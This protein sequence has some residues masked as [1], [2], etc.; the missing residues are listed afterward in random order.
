MPSINE[1]FQKRVSEIVSDAKGSTLVF[2]KGFGI[3]QIQ[4]LIKHPLSILDSGDL[5]RTGALDVVALNEKWLDIISTIKLSQR[6]LV[7][8]YEEL[9][10]IQEFLPRIQVDKIIVVENNILSPWEPSCLPYEQAL[11]LFDYQQEEHEPRDNLLQLLTRFYGDVKLLDGEKALVLP[12][13]LDDETIT[14]ESFWNDEVVLVNIGEAE[15]IE[16]DSTRD[17]IY[18]L[19]LLNGMNTPA[20]FLQNGNK[21]EPR[22]HA[23]ASALTSLG[24]EF[25]IEELDLYIEQKEYDDEQFLPCL[26]KYWGGDAYFR[27]LSFYKDPDRSRDIEVMSQGY[28]ISEIVDQCERAMDGDTYSNVFITAPT[29]SGKS[30]L[31]QL[32]A[33]HL[34]EKYNLVTIVVSPLIALMNDQVDQLQRERGISIAACIN[35]SMT[36]DERIDTIGQVQSGR[37]SLLYLAPELLLTTHLQTFLGGRNVGL[38]VI[39]EAHTVTSWGRDFRSDYWFLGDFIKK[40]KR[41]GLTFPVLCL[42]ATAVYSGKDDVVKDTIHELGLDK[43]ILHIGNVKRENI[44][45][46]IL[47]HDKDKLMTKVETVKMALTLDRMRKFILNQEKVL[48]Y[49]PYRSQVDQIHSLLEAKERIKVRRYHGK[50]PS[51]ERKIVERSYKTG[52]ALGL[53]CTKAFGMGIDVSDIAHVIHF[54][55]TGTLADY[56]QEIGRAARNPNIQGVAHI[57]Y[58]PSDLRYV[59]VLNGISEMRQYQLKEMLKKICAIYNAKKRRNLLISSETFEY[60][61]KEEE[62]ENR[63]KCGLMLL[64][65]DLDNKY[66]FPVLVVRPKTM[67]SKNYVNVPAEIESAWIRK[68]GCYAK[69]QDGDSDRT[70]LSRNQA[71][72]S[73]VKVYSTGN[74]FLVNMS[75]IWENCYPDRSFGLFK[76]E[77]FEEEFPADG[78]KY[79]VAP[80]ARVEI[81]YTKDYHTVCQKIECVLGT[82]VD[83]FGK[84]KNAAIKQFTQQQ[85]EADMAEIMGEKIVAHDKMTL[86]LDV[87]TENVDENAAYTQDRSQIRVLRKRKQVGT[88]DTVYFVSNVAY[89]RLTNFFNRHLGQCSPNAEDGTFYR[90]YPL[91]PNKPIEI[92]P[93]VRVLELLG[94][95]SYEI[96]GGE[97]A[98]VFIRINDPAKLIRL[99]DSKYSN[100]VL[101]SIQ[102]RHRSNQKL[103]SAF[104]MSDMTNDERWEFIEQYFL[105]NEQLISDTLCLSN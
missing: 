36:I 4:Y 97:K 25:A 26:R 47:C 83:I 81:R 71:R 70:I 45:F 20:L 95:A 85:F 32:P 40:A 103:L 101:Q 57:D 104:F 7:G 62:A 90:F 73:D 46:D 94:L 2:F 10:A 37:K 15:R 76:K 66:S 87:F 21:M 23:L 68:Y 16:V 64:A 84:Y 92:M 75:D 49:F 58:F 6:P 80:R 44:D 91:T 24:I 72:A 13:T 11:K 31:F 48:T 43:T 102:D 79:H 5:V 17:W 52:E 22:Q 38:V 100:S 60:L 50:L 14:K 9:L 18:R 30:I 41:D 96:R 55:P 53:V 59:R 65:K 42:T 89:A 69:L 86:L 56:V 77:F 98:E 8:F 12:V 105:G 63:T 67:L 1:I 35:S 19:E 99:A 51:A 93:L 28:I 3:P 34:A 74:T 39:D 27:P 33:L 29:G 78:V 54:A 61:F 88:E 82:M